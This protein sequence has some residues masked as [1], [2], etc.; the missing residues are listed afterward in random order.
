MIGS[1]RHKVET[2][3]SFITHNT[4]IIAKWSRV[5]SEVIVYTQVQTAPVLS[6]CFS[7][8]AQFLQLYLLSS[9]LVVQNPKKNC[10]HI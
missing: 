3:F 7:S 1:I 5:L 6:L 10:D 2:G 4:T 8:V 9:S